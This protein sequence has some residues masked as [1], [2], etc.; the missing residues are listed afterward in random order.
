MQEKFLK[1]FLK[2]SSLFSTL[3]LCILL[4]NSIVVSISFKEQLN[5]PNYFLGDST[6]EQSII[7]S[8]ETVLR[9]KFYLDWCVKNNITMVL[10]SPPSYKESQVYIK[11]HDKI[12]N[13]YKE[14]ANNKT[15]YFLDY[16]NSYLCYDK[17][18]FYNS[19]HLNKT[20][21]ELFSKDLSQKIKK[22]TKFKIEA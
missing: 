6:F 11:N 16:S 14:Y 7:L 20:G 9:F 2:F 22:N 12:L 5:K 19:Q 1:T 3:I 13:L 8:K 4:L 21:A 18:Y 17:K 15:I 10:V